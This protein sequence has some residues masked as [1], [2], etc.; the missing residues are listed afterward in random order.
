M[1]MQS[2]DLIVVS[3][4]V[5]IRGGIQQVGA[6]ADIPTEVLGTFSRSDQIPHQT[7]CPRADYRRLAATRHQSCTGNKK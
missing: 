5:L 3:T 4:N 6:K 7:P 2:I 1:P